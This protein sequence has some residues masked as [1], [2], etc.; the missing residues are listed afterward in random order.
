[1]AFN[2]ISTFL[3]DIERACRDH[4]PPKVIHIL[5]M[6][7]EQQ[8]MLQKALNDQHKLLMLIAKSQIMQMQGENIIEKELAKMSKRYAD[9]TQDIVKSV[10]NKDLADK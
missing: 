8:H 6:M 4:L 5:V 3:E 7:N 1:M 10:D 2:I 9:P